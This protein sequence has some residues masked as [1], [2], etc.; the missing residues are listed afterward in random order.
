MRKYEGGRMK[1]A[2]A[3]EYLIFALD[4][5]SVVKYNLA[6]HETIGKSG[7]PVRDLKTQLRGYSIY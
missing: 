6:T 4:D 1:I 7:K 3:Q 5:G 2:K